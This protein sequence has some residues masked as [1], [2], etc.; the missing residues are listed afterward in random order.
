MKDTWRNNKLKSR[1]K[2]NCKKLGKSSKCSSWYFSEDSSNTG[3]TRSNS[4]KQTI[5]GK[6]VSGP[7]LPCD[8]FFQLNPAIK[9]VGLPPGGR[10]NHRFYILCFY[11]CLYIDYPHLK[12]KK[13]KFTMLSILCAPQAGCQEQEYETGFEDKAWRRIKESAAFIQW[14]AV[15]ANFRFLQKESVQILHAH[16]HP[17]VDNL[18]GSESVKV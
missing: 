11:L 5:P 15:P 9:L 7:P 12:M 6:R 4:D 8:C 1:Y 18:P 16:N 2:R 10:R 14:A 3:L 13:Q 17:E